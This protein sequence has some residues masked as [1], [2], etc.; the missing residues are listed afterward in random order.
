MFTK[1]IQFAIILTITMAG[2]STHVPIDGV[3]GTYVASYPFGTETLTLNHDGS[4]IQR[5]EIKG[6]P[7]ITVKG[8]WS[9]D[10]QM[11]YVTFH[12]YMQVADGFGKL[13]TN[14]RDVPHEATE[15]V[16]RIFLRI[17]INSGAQFPYIK[18]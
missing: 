13:R 4:L 12:E 7:Q 18:R 8:S 2:C 16:E 15:P 5:V 9:F 11:G 1:R 3:E 14:W 17:V 10:P 6:Q